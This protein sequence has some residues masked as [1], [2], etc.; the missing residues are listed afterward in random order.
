M[1]KVDLRR[2]DYSS[3]AHLECEIW[4]A[5]Y[6]HRF[7]KFA[8]L[9][10]QFMRTQLGLSAFN[11]LRLA[12]YF[13]VASVEYRINQNHKESDM[14]VRNLAK[15]YRV[16][17]ANSD[18]SFDYKKA[19]KY[20]LEWW[21]IQRYGSKEKEALEKGM[22][23]SFAVVYNTKASK[24]MRYARPRAQATRLRKKYMLERKVEPKW[25]EI[26]KLLTKSWN[27]LYE[28]VNT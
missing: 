28:S 10:Y 24:L 6:R 14:T 16:I 7:I 4:R 1:A 15:F 13:T 18:K 12:Y 8:V 9:T 23:K 21:D 20:E 22:A 2:F 3:A 19:G 27:A 17:S 5:Y 26:E 11:T 25:G